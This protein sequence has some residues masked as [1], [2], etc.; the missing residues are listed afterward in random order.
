MQFVILNQKKMG[1]F[2]IVSLNEKYCQNQ[3]RIFISFHLQNK[4]L[5]IRKKIAVNSEKD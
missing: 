2:F 3:F 5:L 4:M 1:L